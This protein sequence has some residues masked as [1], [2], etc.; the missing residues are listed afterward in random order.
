MTTNIQLYG[1]DNTNVTASAT[2]GAVVEIV[3]AVSGDIS[4]ANRIDHGMLYYNYYTVSG[5][6]SLANTIDHGML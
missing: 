4:L 2:R 1:N 6:I 3:C 5:N